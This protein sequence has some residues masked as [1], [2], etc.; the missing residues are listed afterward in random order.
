MTL[1]TWR[2]VSLVSFFALGPG[3]MVTPGCSTLGSDCTDESS[4]GDASVN[5]LQLLGRESLVELFLQLL[6]LSVLKQTLFSMIR[7]NLGNETCRI[8]N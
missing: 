4:F 8:T 7:R 5:T 6:V 1:I 3:L 2:A